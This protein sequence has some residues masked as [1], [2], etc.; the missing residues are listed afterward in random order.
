MRIAPPACLR[1]ARATAVPIPD[2]PV[3]VGIDGLRP[4]RRIAGG[5]G[6]PA[7]PYPRHVAPMS[8]RQLKCRAIRYQRFDEI[9][10]SARL[11]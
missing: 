4:G 2:Q 1:W 10:A 11:S 6:V 8:H 7:A 3:R 9:G 5:I